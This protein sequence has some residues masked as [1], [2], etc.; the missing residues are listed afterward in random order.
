VTGPKRH[1]GGAVDAGHL[2]DERVLTAAQRRVLRQMG[3]FTLNR[4]FYMGGGTAV[5]LYLGHR[6]SVDF[7]WFTPEAL[8]DPLALAQAL[9]E[10]LQNSGATLETYGL[11]PGTLHGAVGGVNVSFLE[12]KY[13]LLQPLVEWGDIPCRAA[14]LD[15]LA[16]M[17]LVAVVQRGTRKDFVDVYALGTAHR[18]LRELLKLYERKYG[19]ADLGHVLVGLSYFDDAEHTPMPP[20]LWRHSWSTIRKTIQT[21]V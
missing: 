9:R 12:Y 3:G 15:D 4:G 11:E 21:W 20:M 17:K 8:D 10:S 6:R 19:I 18:P 16:C 5:A 1:R 7:D 13:P 2:P 14:S